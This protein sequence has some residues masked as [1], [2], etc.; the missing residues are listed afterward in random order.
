MRHDKY[1]K[2]DRHDRYDRHGLSTTNDV[3]CITQ[4]DIIRT[5][6]GEWRIT[7]YC[8]VQREDCGASVGCGV[9]VGEWR[10][11]STDKLIEWPFCHDRWSL[12]RV[13]SMHETSRL[14]H[15]L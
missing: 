2:Y 14:M 11:A 7:A 12:V 1:N 8:G 5:E 10:R 15:A 3:R 9:R 13:Q 6:Y 4:Y